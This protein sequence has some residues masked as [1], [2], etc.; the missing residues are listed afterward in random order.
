M[1]YMIDEGPGRDDFVRYWKL[2]VGRMYLRSSPHAI[3]LNNVIIWAYIR[4]KQWSTTRPHMLQSSRT[5]P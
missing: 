3:C 1:D 4:L 5:S 2:M